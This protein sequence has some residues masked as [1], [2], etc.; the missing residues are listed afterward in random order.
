M[1]FGKHW[2]AML[3]ATAIIVGCN[4]PER[5][6]QALSG[7][8]SAT[9]IEACDEHLFNDLHASLS[10]DENTLRMVRRHCG[11]SRESTGYSQTIAG[12]GIAMCILP[13]YRRRGIGGRDPRR[14][15]GRRDHLPPRGDDRAAAVRVP[16]P[17][18]A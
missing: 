14:R 1:R 15:P 5:L 11:L 9:Q 10:W 17:H 18:A 16:A 4:A 7:S 2:I 13:E 6:D 8:M 3:V 12:Y